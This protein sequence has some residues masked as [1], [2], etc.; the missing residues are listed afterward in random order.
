VPEELKSE[1]LARLFELADELQSRHLQSL[2]GA[3]ASVLVEGRSKSSSAR[4]SGR[5]E[6]HEIVHIDAPPALDLCGRLIS[7]RISEAYKR[8]L[9]GIPIEP[10]ADAGPPYPPAPPVTLD[11]PKTALRLPLMST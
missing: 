6:R 11:K 8:S 10:W 7:V 4:V 2:V 3:T 9:I 1:R 5:S